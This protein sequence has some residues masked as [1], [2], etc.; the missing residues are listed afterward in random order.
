MPQSESLPVIGVRCGALRVRDASHNR[1]I[2]YRADADAILVVDVY[3]EKTRKMPQAVIDQCWGRL[4]QYDEVAR[5][6]GSRKF[7]MVPKKH[8]R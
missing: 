6:V 7:K 1:R 4:K 5:R 3:P 8:Q 2:I